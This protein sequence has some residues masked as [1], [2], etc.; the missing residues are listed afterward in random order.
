[1]LMDMASSM[2]GKKLEALPVTQDGQTFV[3]DPKALKPENVEVDLTR[4]TTS[5]GK[6]VVEGGS[7]KTLDIGPWGPYAPD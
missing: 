3:V 7:P 1:M 2:A 4:I 5:G 6:L